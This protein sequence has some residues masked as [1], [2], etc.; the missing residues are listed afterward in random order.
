MPDNVEQCVVWLNESDFA[1]V[2]WAFRFP[3]DGYFGKLF[4]N[5]EVLYATGFHSSRKECFDE[6]LGELKRR[7][8]MA[9]SELEWIGGMIEK[10]EEYDEQI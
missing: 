1:R 5:G 3:N 7:L 10:L 4:R 8:E 9:K 6:I 2:D